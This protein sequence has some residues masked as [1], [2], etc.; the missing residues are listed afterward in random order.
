VSFLALA[1]SAFLVVSAIFLEVSVLA[2]SILAESIL[3]ESVAAESDLPLQAAKE[4]AI[5]KAKAPILNAFFML[6]FFLSD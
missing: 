2:E 5:T 4:T 1:V 6:I 3:A